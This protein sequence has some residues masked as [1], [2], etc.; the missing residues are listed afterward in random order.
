MK[1]MVPWCLLACACG[2]AAEP[3]P[4]DVVLRLP[5]GDCRP[6]ETCRFDVGALTLGTGVLLAFDLVNLGDA[7]AEV[8][9]LNVVGSAGVQVGMPTS[10]TVRARSTLPLA[11]S[12]SPDE[13]GLLESMLVVGTTASPAS[14]RLRIGV[15]GLLPDLQITRLCDLG[16]VPVGTLSAPCEI[17]LHNPTQADVRVDQ[18]YFPAGPFVPASAQV[19]PFVLPV[20][21]DVVFRVAAQPTQPGVAVGF[22]S[23]QRGPISFTGETILQVNGI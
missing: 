19:F 7:D 17:V 6:D 12:V 14:I 1:R 21:G 16:D 8:Q 10:G 13:A 22:M 9:Q 15:E 4:P 5:A 2:S 11:L 3:A 20:G 18:V 23:Y